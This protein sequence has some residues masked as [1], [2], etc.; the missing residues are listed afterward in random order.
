MIKYKQE[1]D[2]TFSSCKNLCD[3]NF[4]NQ[5]FCIFKIGKHKNKCTVYKVVTLKK[6]DQNKIGV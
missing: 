5:C 6:M 2:H 3:N 1:K 4:K